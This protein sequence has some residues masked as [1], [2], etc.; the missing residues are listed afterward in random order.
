MPNEIQM[1][2]GSMF[3]PAS[4]TALN[5]LANDAIWTSESFANSTNKYGAEVWVRLSTSNPAGGG[6]AEIWLLEA[7]GDGTELVVDSSDDG[8]TVGW[9]KTARLITGNG[10]NPMPNNAKQLGILNM[11]VSG[12]ADEYVGKFNTLNRT[13]SLGPNWGIMIVNRA[14]AA[15]AST[16]NLIHCYYITPEIQ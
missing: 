7:D 11:G 5:S 3:Q 2:R 9:D 13:E 16:L 8:G 14:G 15:L 12:S 6:Y 10:P 4:Y 1:K